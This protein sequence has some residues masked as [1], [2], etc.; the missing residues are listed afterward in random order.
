[1]PVVEPEALPIGAVVRVD[2]APSTPPVAS[3]GTGIEE[4]TSAREEEALVSADESAVGSAPESAHRLMDG[5]HD[6]YEMARRSAEARRR[7]REAA[8]DA[9]TRSYA[10]RLRAVLADQQ[11]I[12]EGTTKSTPAAARTQ[13]A[14]L[15]PD[16]Q[17]AVREAEE[18]EQLSSAIP[19]STLDPGRRTVID[20]A[21]DAQDDEVAWLVGVLEDRQAEAPSPPE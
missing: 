5:G 2:P 6:P 16:L 10:D 7:R 19:W 3:I 8:Q 1:M 14:R 20:F 13:A 4:G 12:A 17:A 11:Q 15:I 21:L 9:D 18:A